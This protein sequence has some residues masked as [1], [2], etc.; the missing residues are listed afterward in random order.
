LTSR[1]VLQHELL[2]DVLR[3]AALVSRPVRRMVDRRL[4]QEL[5]DY[6][7]LQAVTPPPAEAGPALSLLGHPDADST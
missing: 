2:L 7:S 5:A 6:A 1:A 4:R 3:D